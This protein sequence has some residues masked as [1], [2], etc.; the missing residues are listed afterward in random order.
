MT[1]QKGYTVVDDVNLSVVGVYDNEYP[2]HYKEDNHH[3][4]FGVMYKADREE[5]IR[6]LIEG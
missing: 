6:E 1:L 3:Y 5:E 2:A 4:I